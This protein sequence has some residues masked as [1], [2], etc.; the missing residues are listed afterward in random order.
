M[1]TFEHVTL[2][3]LQNR[4]QSLKL[5]SD[6][7]MT[8][9]IDDSQLEQAELRRKKALEAMEKLEGSGTGDLLEA[10]LEERKKDLEL[11]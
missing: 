9:Q 2:S 7:R 4:L 3:E 10:L 8:V 5:P 11:W 6:T 1:P